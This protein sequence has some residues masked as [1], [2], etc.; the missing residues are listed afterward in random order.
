MTWLR[1]GSGT[2]RISP[3]IGWTPGHLEGWTPVYHSSDRSPCSHSSPSRPK[4]TLHGSCIPSRTVD[5]DSDCEASLRLLRSGAERTTASSASS[6]YSGA[7]DNGDA[8]PRGVALL[9][10]LLLLPIAVVVAAPTVL[11]REDVMEAALNAPEPAVLA[12]EERRH[13][14]EGRRTRLLSDATKT[15][16]RET[17]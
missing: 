16:L 12:R 10:A 8:P 7:V 4:L 14:G 5:C 9:P 6:S 3:V 13:Q 15:R 17:P 2:D 1:L 11:D